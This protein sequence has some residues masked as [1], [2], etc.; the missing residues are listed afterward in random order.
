MPMIAISQKP[1]PLA[2][3]PDDWFYHD[4]YVV[5]GPVGSTPGVYRCYVKRLMAGS[6][7]TREQ[8]G[9]WRAEQDSVV[10]IS[11]LGE[12][13]TAVVNESA[14]TIFYMP[15]HAN[16]KGELFAFHHCP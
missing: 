7:L 8:N 11:Q 16:F 2:G 3:S 1:L 13:Q 6:I 4:S 9:T 5:L 15:D 12:Y 14:G 10:P